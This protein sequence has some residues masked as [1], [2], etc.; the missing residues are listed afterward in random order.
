MTTLNKIINDIRNIKFKGLAA[1]DYNVSNR[2][3]VHWINKLREQLLTEMINKGVIIDDTFIQSINIE[4]ACRDYSN[5][6]CLSSIF[7]NG[8][9]ITAMVS[10]TIPAPIPYK[11]S[12]TSKGSIFTFFGKASGEPIQFNNWESV[13]YEQYRKHRQGSFGS[14]KDNKV[15]LFDSAGID[16]IQPRGLFQDPREVVNFNCGNFCFDYDSPYPISGKMENVILQLIEA[17]YLKL[18]LNPAVKQDT[19]NDSKEL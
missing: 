19:T 1:D 13:Y 8:T 3:I 10:N 4:L 14:F 11:D 9:G 15:Y 17:Q 7:P 5:D 2:Q 18:L 12:F 6:N 16:V